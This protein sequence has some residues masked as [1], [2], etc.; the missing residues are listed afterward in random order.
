MMSV[1]MF[2]GEGPGEPELSFGN[3][4][5]KGS[6]GKKKKQVPVHAL[7]ALYPLPE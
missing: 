3:Y 2:F 7:M 6:G 5:A 4:N 1:Q